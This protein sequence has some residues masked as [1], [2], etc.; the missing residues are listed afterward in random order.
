MTS[1]YCYL[2]YRSIDILKRSKMLLELFFSSFQE[3]LK[4][5]DISE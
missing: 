1:I 4:N 2:L 5:N 3:T